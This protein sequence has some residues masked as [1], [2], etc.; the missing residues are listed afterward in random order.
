MGFDDLEG[1]L[2]K[3][4][5]ALGKAQNGSGDLFKI[6]TANGFDRA[7]IKALNYS[8]AL[9][10]VANLIKNAKTPPASFRCCC[11]RRTGISRNASKSVTAGHLPTKSQ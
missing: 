3:F 9:D 6:L 11:S 4:S 2:L 10:V 5:K 1:G 8:Q 7:K